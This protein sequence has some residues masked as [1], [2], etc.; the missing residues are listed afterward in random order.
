MQPELKKGIVNVV[1]FYAAGFALTLI[2]YFVFD[3]SYPHAPSPY[4]MIGLLFVFVGGFMG[5]VALFRYLIVNRDKRL[6]AAI[7][8][9]LTILICFFLWIY[10]SIVDRS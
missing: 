6:L 5:L 4:M 10:F 7:F 3:N 2:A 9:H 8:G 1:I